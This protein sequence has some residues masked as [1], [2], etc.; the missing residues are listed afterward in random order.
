MWVWSVASPPSGRVYPS[1]RNATLF[2]P[3]NHETI[4]PPLTVESLS[5]VRGGVNFGPS[6]LQ[7]RDISAFP[8]QVIALCR[9]TRSVYHAHGQQTVSMMPPL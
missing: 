4:C 8:K 9:V 1:M 6:F 7:N 3:E 2:L 5:S